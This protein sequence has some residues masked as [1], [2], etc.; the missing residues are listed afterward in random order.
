MPCISDD[1]AEQIILTIARF[2]PEIEAIV[3]SYPEVRMAVVPEY[4]L[5]RPAVA[6]AADRPRNAEIMRGCLTIQCINRVALVNEDVDVDS[7]EDVLWAISNRILDTKKVTSTR[8]STSGG[9][10]LSSASTRPSISTISGTSV[11]RS[12][13]SRGVRRRRR[14]T[15]RDT[16]HAVPCSAGAL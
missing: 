11:R 12:S 1:H 10:T 2:Q 13:R 14:R 9:T 3:A 7:A 15:P 6:V 5:G 16:D 8:A 4:G